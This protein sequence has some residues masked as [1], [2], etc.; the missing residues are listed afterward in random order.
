MATVQPDRI[1]AGFRMSEKKCSAASLRLQQAFASVDLHQPLG[2]LRG[3][4][5]FILDDARAVSECQHG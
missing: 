1:G 4:I 2:N 5:E 3:A